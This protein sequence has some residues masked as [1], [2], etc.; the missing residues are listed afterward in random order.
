MATIKKSAKLNFYKFVSPVKVNTGGDKKFVGLQMGINKNTQAIN[1]IGAT[2]NS[3]GKVMG[4]FRDGQ[5]K[6][7]EQIQASSKEKFKPVYTKPTGGPDMGRLEEGETPET[8]MPGWLE[9]LFNIIKDFLILALAGPVLSWLSDP[10][11]RQTIKDTL[12]T[13]LKVVQFISNFIGDRVKGLIDS[14]HD[15]FFNKEQNWWEKLGSFFSAFVNFAG[16]FVAI[17]WLTNPM[18]I[19]KDFKSVLG[20]FTKNLKKSR[21]KLARR[22]KG[23]GAVAAV[24]TL[25]TIVVTSMND[26]GGSDDDPSPEAAEGGPVPLR[27]GGG[28]INGPMSGYPVSLDGGRST[29]FIGHGLEY[30]AQKANGGFVVPL[31]TPA[32]QN[33]PS[34]TS[35]RIGEASR[36]GF[37][38]GGMF[39][40]MPGF[41][42]GGMLNDLQVPEFAGGGAV[43]LTGPAKRLVGNDTEFLK[44]VNQVSAKIGANPADL[45]GLMASESG[46][47]PQ[48]RNKSGATGLIQFMTA[49]ARGVGTSTAA[50]YGMNRVQQM[51]YVEKFLTR[52]AP[53]N[54]TPG[55]LY[56]SVFLPA[57]AKKPAN[58]VVAKRGGFRDDW[59]NHPAAWYTHNSGLDLNNDGSIT[60]AELGE[61]IRQKQK[62]F[63]I[64]G[65]SRI[66]VSD[67]SS[68]ST[69]AMNAT[70]VEK[71]M[72][73]FDGVG[74]LVKQLM[75]VF[76]GEGKKDTAPKESGTTGSGEGKPSNIN[77]TDEKPRQLVSPSPP[78]PVPATTASAGATTSQTVNTQTASV[79]NVK[80]ESRSQQA[81][82]IAAMQ[83]QSLMSRQ[84]IAAL[85]QQSLETV[86]KAEN[87]ANS[88]HPVIA[89]AGGS[90]R[91]S[92]VEALESNN[93]L[94]RSRA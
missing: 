36:M 78:P 23:L 22:A 17:R 85:S 93:A 40:S 68:D 41:S 50:R 55:H 86:A 19:V 31:N 47:N 29:S 4:E 3:L 57:F 81:Q 2:I 83:A 63:G 77:Q 24:A 33:N 52:T 26:D 8:V 11:N 9:S 58:Y 1:N 75:S 79:N 54:P 32:T 49:T 6:M 25:A 30:V 42:L 48:A 92:L 18:N 45:L 39:D 60:I 84:R 74:S 66:D 62:S 70:T 69:G 37:D 34:L 87:A 51:D 94:M 44:R 46:L 90:S 10:N 88:K 71:P 12:E 16:L 72:T 82:A 80:S 59:G 89:N 53:K 20:L 76:G 14:L 21:S 7:L 56:T 13:I 27:A 91:K 67:I 35:R 73:L 5:A 15:L 43:T 28:W 61:R 65:G 38:L 64:G